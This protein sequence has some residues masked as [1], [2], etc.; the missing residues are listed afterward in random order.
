MQAVGADMRAQWHCSRKRSIP[1]PAA[2]PPLRPPLRHAP[3]AAL[4]A[5]GD[6]AARGDGATR[7]RDSR[8]GR[9]N[10]MRGPRGSGVARI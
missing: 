7:K 6:A 8:E 4:P 10:E 3:A 5:V 2:A 9:G 1:R